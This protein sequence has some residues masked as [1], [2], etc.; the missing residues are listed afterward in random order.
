MWSSG[1]PWKEMRRFTTRTLKNAG[2]GELKSADAMLIEELE[3][4]IQSLDE[5]RLKNDNVIYMRQYFKIPTFNILWRVMSGYR[6]SYDDQEMRKLIHYVED[7]AEIRTSSTL[8]N[9]TK[10]ELKIFI[11]MLQKLGR[12]WSGASRLSG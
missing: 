11:K 5:D 1:E 9:Y 4:F 6:F 10:A 8:S 3:C 7:V 2:F 12:T